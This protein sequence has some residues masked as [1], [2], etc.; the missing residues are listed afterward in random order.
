[1]KKMI[2]LFLVCMMLFVL[3]GCGAP[4]TDQNPAD[5][6]VTDNQEGDTDALAD[7]SAEAEEDAE[8]ED[9]EPVDVDL[10]QLSSTM[11]YSEVFNMM[12]NPEDYIGKTVKMVGQFTATEALDE[13]YEP[14]PG[15]MYYACYIAD[16]TACC[17]EGVEFELAGDYKYP[18]DYPSLKSVIIVQGE[19]QTYKD[20]DGTYCHLINA[21]FCK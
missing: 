4:A 18:E 7:E 15:K 11:V 12:N 16:A 14:I 10:T 2:C 20:G 9:A 19:F 13:N 6:T 1:M 8:E 21:K 5:Q 17:A 3:A